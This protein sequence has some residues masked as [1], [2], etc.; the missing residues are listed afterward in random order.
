MAK[1]NCKQCGKEAIRGG[2]RLPVFCSLECKGNWQ[3][4]QKSKSLGIDRDWLYQK[5]V[6]DGLSS[7]QIAKMVGRNPKRVYEWMKDLGIPLRKRTW[8]IEPNTQPYHDPEWLKTEYVDKRRS[9]GE[10]S[11]QFGV[12]DAVILYF[13]RE[14]GIKRR[15]I[16][17]ARKV[18]RWGAI[19]DKNPMYGKR[20]EQSANW[21]G[22][23]TPERQAFYSSLEWKSA[24]SLVWKRDNAICQRCG[25]K[26]TPRT[27][28][29]SMH[30]HHIVSFMDRELRTDPANLVLLCADCHRWVHGNE[31]H[32]KEF[33]SDVQKGGA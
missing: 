18:K 21:K 20:G 12:T 13:L 14:F 4:E 2:S 9:A 7:Y 30:I 3:R 11:A 27:K 29:L 26:K 33:L 32:N 8:D 10:I 28:T 16:S 5:Y 25:V 15:N 6:V 19:G 22:G 1:G 24:S 31:N 17:A 23:L